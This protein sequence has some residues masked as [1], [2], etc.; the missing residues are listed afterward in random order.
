[1]L[2]PPKLLILPK[3]LADLPAFPVNFWC[4]QL[5]AAGIKKNINATHKAPKPLKALLPA[6]HLNPAAR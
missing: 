3:P 5:A 6:T 1:M 4:T 2:M